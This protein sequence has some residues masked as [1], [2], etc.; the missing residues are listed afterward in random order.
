MID[1]VA[2]HRM[3]LPPG[4]MPNPKA[5]L[6]NE[7]DRK[8]FEYAS[9]KIERDFS[10][11]SFLD[12]GCF[13]G[14][15]GFLLCDKNA[16]R[17]NIKFHGV[18]LIPELASAARAYAQAHNI[19]STIYTGAFHDVNLYQ[20]YDHVICFESLEH[21]P[22][23]TASQ[24]IVKMVKHARKSVLISLPDQDFRDNPQHQWTPSLEVIQELC[25][26][27]PGFEIKRHEYQDKSIP[28]NFFVRLNGNAES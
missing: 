19:T 28:A 26:H 20:Y 15:L 11:T 16:S 23:L 8:H 3:N 2:L 4:Y 27:Y 5:H 7:R 22:I 1:Y 6:N 14:W 21:V 13:D 18:E 9:S 17:Y 24:Y 25:G 12:V 10:T